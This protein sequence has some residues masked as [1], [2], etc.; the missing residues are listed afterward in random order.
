VITGECTEPLRSLLEFESQKYNLPIKYTRVNL[1]LDL[2]AMESFRPE[3]EIYLHFDDK[4][5]PFAIPIGDELVQIRTS[6]C[7]GNPDSDATPVGPQ[8]DGELVPLAYL[9]GRRVIIPFDLE[10]MEPLNGASNVVNRILDVIAGL[11]LNRA[12]EYIQKYSYRVE[13]DSFAGVMTR[14]L[15]QTLTSME[16]NIMDNEF[17]VKQKTQ[18]IVELVQKNQE[19]KLSIEAIQAVGAARKREN[20]IREFRELLKLQPKPYRSIT[21]DDSYIKAETGPI[22]I[23]HEDYVYHMGR[24]EVE[25]AFTTNSLEIRN[26]EPDRIVD[27]YHHP[28]V[29]GSGLP[30]LGNISLSLSKLLAA[31]QYVPALVLIHQYLE[32]YND[33]DAYLKLERWDPDWREDED[34]SCE[35]CFRNSATLDCVE[36]DRDGC[37]YWDDRYT[38]CAE[39]AQLYTCVRC[40]DCDEWETQ[41]E[42]CRDSSSPQSCVTCDENRCPNAGDVQLCSDEH[43]GDECIDC[44][45]HDC[46]FYTEE[47][48]EDNNAESID[49]PVC[50]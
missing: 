33:A 5:L 9:N 40:R 23:V 3:I 27:G 25:I 29:S 6:V 36:C 48:E 16:R 20:A 19:M 42:L 31:K 49:S 7:S 30:C 32:S 22:E 34:E 14:A 1:D 28:H 45:N 24:F 11:A 46:K 2:P 10:C 17:D 4:P 12:A 39:F 18:E 50:T 26:L 35:D 44:D 38:R 37:P 8:V 15:D 47:K 43:N 41:V 13:E 21:F